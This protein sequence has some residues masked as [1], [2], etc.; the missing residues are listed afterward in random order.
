MKINAV[1]Y[2]DE[3]LKKAAVLWDQKEPDIAFQ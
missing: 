3:V 2:Q 1:V